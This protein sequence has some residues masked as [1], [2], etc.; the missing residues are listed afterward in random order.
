[1]KTTRKILLGSATALLALAIAC[2]LFVSHAKRQLGGQFPAPGQL[3]DIGGYRLHLHCMG[4]GRPTIVFEAGLNE[5][6]LAW[7]RVQSEAA[8]FARACTYDRAGLGWSEPSPLRRTGVNM[9]K[10]LHALLARS[11]T[12]GPLIL[13]GHSFGGLLARHYLHTY[14]DEVAGLVLIDAAHEEYLE[15]IPALAKLARQTAD[16]FQRLSHISRLGL[17]ALAPE[18]IPTRGLEGEAQAAYRALLAT[19]TF[20]DAAAAETAAIEQN[21]AAARA[22]PLGQLGALPLVV[23]SRGQ[24]D[25]LPLLNSE[26][27]AHYEREWRAMQESLVTL[28]TRS[29]QVVASRSGHAIPLTEPQLVIDAIRSLIMR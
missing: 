22:L 20:F 2:W 19:G 26:E 18:R 6:S 7:T 10:E 1:M 15:R 4:A 11:G 8:Q 21:L 12:G 14:P 23:L 3:V 25:P 16:E 5:F 13:V 17:M 28:S 9:V 27:N 29:R 24:P